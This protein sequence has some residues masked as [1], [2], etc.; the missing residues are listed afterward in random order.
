MKIKQLLLRCYAEREAN[1]QWF[2]ICLDLNI[3]A[4]ADSHQEVKEK[5]HAQILRYVREALTVDAQYAEGLL[6]RR[7]PIGFF[8][9]Y[10]MMRLRAAL[11]RPR[12]ACATT[13]GSS[14]QRAFVEPISLVPA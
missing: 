11:R 10:Y 5:L 6:E 9:R 4:Q 7:A 1:G 2:A 3:A 12:Q 14:T 8:L 13:V